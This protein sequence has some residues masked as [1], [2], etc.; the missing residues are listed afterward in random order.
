MPMTAREANAD[1]AA[2]VRVVAEA[3]WRDT[4]A[5]LLAGSTIEAFL[6][7]AYA[8]DRIVRRIA[9]DT[10]L[11]AEA[12]GSVVAFADAILEADRV[13][14]AAIYALPERRGQ[15]AGTLLLSA[16]RARFP[17]RPIA[18]DVLVGNGTGE[19][20]YEH[21]GFVSRETLVAGLLGEA[22]VER[23]WWLDPGLDAGLHG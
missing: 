13:N 23:R 1:D 21:R 14:L 7:R 2:A 11:V 6:E 10:F 22:V 15:G 5:G 8:V 19:P 17:G 9:A 16:L 12:D 4:Y 18:A 3:A 20:F